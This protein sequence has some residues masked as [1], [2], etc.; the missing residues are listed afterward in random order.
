M[1]NILQEERMEFSNPEWQDSADQDPLYLS[2]QRHLTILQPYRYGTT[3][4]VPD[5]SPAFS[6]LWYLTFLQPFQYYGN[7]I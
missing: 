4:P 7:G 5:H 6:V 1:K 3:V 2:V